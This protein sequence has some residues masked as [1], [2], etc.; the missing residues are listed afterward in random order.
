MTAESRHTEDQPKTLGG[1][2][3]TLSEYAA[4]VVE[5]L[6]F[7]N[8]KRI[9]LKG[10]IID[11][12][13]TAYEAIVCEFLTDRLSERDANPYNLAKWFS[14]KCVPQF[15]DSTYVF[16]FNYLREKDPRSEHRKNEYNLEILRYRVWEKLSDNIPTT[17]R[18]HI[19]DIRRRFFD[20]PLDSR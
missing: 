5:E 8:G 18:A 15:Y 1:I 12:R 14:D 16:P 3:N 11:N 17:Y 9:E 7:R 20:A 2:L 10:I 4:L 6:R 13:N 19:I